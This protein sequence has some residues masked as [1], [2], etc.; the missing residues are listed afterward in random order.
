MITTPD[1]TAAL[2]RSR[3]NIGYARKGCTVNDIPLLG[4]DPTT[5]LAPEWTDILSCAHSLRQ[6]NG[7]DAPINVPMA[8]QRMIYEGG[9]PGNL[10]HNDP[11]DVTQATLEILKDPSL[12]AKFIARLSVD[13]PEI[14]PKK[15]IQVDRAIEM[16]KTGIFDL[17]EHPVV[18]DL[19]CGPGGTKT[20]SWQK[21][22]GMVIGVE[23]QQ[24]KGY[25]SYRVQG[26]GLPEYAVADI[27]ALPF[28]P[29]IADIAVMS[30]VTSYLTQQ[31]LTEVL[32]EAKRVLKDYGVLIVGPLEST[33]DGWG[34]F[35]KMPSDDHGY[36]DEIV[37]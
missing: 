27:G 5:E 22:N 3:D 6:N 37:F 24:S 28:A 9:F 20:Q 8:V 32:D 18:L 36:F 12:A 11:A 33:V 35:Q 1:T 31:K 19:G 16:I 13:I 15:G 23:R 25:S 29:R 14:G 30:Y 10:D 7:I 21:L 2:I 4:A 34:Y 26:E 17:P